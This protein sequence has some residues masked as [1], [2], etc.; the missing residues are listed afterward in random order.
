MTFE[1]QR[2]EVDD[3]SEDDGSQFQ[4]LEG[5]NSERMG[6]GETVNTRSSGSEIHSSEA[7]VEVSEEES[8][9]SAVVDRPVMG[10]PLVK[11]LCQFVNLV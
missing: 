5:G 9:N 11:G 7:I 10:A 6:Q 3:G 4:H 2:C 1:E 8:E